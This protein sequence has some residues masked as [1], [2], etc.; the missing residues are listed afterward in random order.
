MSGPG[1]GFDSTEPYDTIPDS[2]SNITEAS[3]D[4]TTITLP[5]TTYDTTTQTECTIYDARPLFGPVAGGTEVLLSGDGLPG[6]VPVNVTFSTDSFLLLATYLSLNFTSSSTISLVT[7][8]LSDLL[9]ISKRLPIIVNYEDG[10]SLDTG[11]NFTYL[12]DPVISDVYPL[13]HIPQGGT[14]ITVNGTNLNSVSDPKMN[15]TQIHTFETTTGSLT[16]TSKNYITDCTVAG[17]NNMTCPVAELDLPPDYADAIAEAQSSAPRQR[18]QLS[19]TSMVDF[20]IGFW[21]AVDTFK[22]ISEVQG[23][24]DKKFQLSP[25]VFEIGDLPDYNPKKEMYI[26]INYV[27]VDHDYEFLKPKDPRNALPLLFLPDAD[28]Q[29]VRV[30]HDYEFLKPKD[31]RNA[32]PRI[33]M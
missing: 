13:Q 16:V 14:T 33:L 12:G 10:T 7:Y 11:F 20:S 28:P 21:D 31:P 29:Y 1:T 6:C 18:K 26:D 17:A 27:R 15:L 5:H 22:N 32:L 24:E 23:L 8:P 30:D 19:N 4:T 25:P 3:N 9:Y 2:T